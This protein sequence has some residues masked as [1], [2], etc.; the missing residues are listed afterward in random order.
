MITGTTVMLISEMITKPMA[1]MVT[2]SEIAFKPKKA[3]LFL[4]V[5]DD[6]QGIEHRFHSAV[7]APKRNEQ[8]CNHRE[9]QFLR[10]LRCQRWI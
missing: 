8:S 1:P 3:S 5:V 7:C 9:A 4:F 10:R 6:I 2:A